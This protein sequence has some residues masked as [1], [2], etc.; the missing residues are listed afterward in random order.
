L[1]GDTAFALRILPDGG[2]LV[3]DT[4]SVIRL[5]ISGNIIRTYPSP[6]SGATLFALNRDPDNTSFWTGDLNGG[7]M[8]K[9]DIATGAV[10]MTIDTTQHGN[11][12]ALG[13]ITVFGEQTEALGSI[14]GQKFN[15]LNG[16]GVKDAGEL[17]LSGWTIVLTKPD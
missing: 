3:A 13:G 5:D 4:Q 6:V 8:F 12:V 9:I 10:L 15:D 11:F 14:S 7:K 1:P 17:G 2:V 16:N